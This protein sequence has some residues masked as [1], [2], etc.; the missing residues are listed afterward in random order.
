[1]T[2]LLGHVR[3]NAVAYVAL[4]IAL[5]GTGYAAANLPAGSVGAAQIRNHVIQPVKL[6]PRYIGGSVRLWASVSA[7]GK[8]VAGGRGVTVVPQ[9]SVPGDY[10]VSPS[11][12]S[13]IATPRGCEAVASVDDSSAVPGFANAQL[14]VGSR[15]E[16]PRWQVVIA[17]DEA[18]GQST[19]L[20]FDFAVIC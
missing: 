10:L 13:R 14:V 6:D 9:G 12:R 20:P 17:T 15:G 2:R 11:R 4:F 7:S 8:V 16:V 5:G 3:S 18:G 19:A 1:M